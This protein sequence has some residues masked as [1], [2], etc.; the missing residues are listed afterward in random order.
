MVS[1]VTRCW[2]I[3][4]IAGENGMGTIIAGN[5]ACS[6]SIVTHDSLGCCTIMLIVYGAHT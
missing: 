1:S 3:D 2:D 5:D 6:N 4:P